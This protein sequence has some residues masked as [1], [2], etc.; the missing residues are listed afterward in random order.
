MTLVSQHSFYLLY[1]Y[2]WNVK[3]LLKVVVLHDLIRDLIFNVLY[4][5]MQI[6]CKRIYSGKMVKSFFVV[7]EFE[8]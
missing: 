4:V 7:V 5:Y 6:F 8:I 3:M 1:S 2:S